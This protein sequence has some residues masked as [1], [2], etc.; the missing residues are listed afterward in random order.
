VNPAANL[1]LS[2]FERLASG[3]EL[4]LPNLGMETLHHVHADDVAQAFA[5]ALDKRKQAVGEAFN[6]VSERAITL[7]GYAEAIAELAGQPCRLAFLPW[8]TWRETVPEGDSDETWDHIAHSPSVSIDKARR[9]LGYMPAYTSLQAIGESLAWLVA[10]D[11]LK[12]PNLRSS[13]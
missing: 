1:D 12:A 8:N 9:L 6:V 13:L 10:N 2:V 11:K 5:L 7:R 4:V 3:E